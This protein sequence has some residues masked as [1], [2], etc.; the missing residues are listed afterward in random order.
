MRNKTES[1]FSP[2]SRANPIMKPLKS[3]QISMYSM[4]FCIY[5]VCISMLRFQL[6]YKGV[7]YFPAYNKYE[8]QSGQFKSVKT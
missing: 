3:E 4:Y 6:L 2:R 7:K 5:V 8:S 1:K